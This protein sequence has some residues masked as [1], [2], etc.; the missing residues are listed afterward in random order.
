[1][2]SERG[3]IFAKQSFEDWF[4]TESDKI[5]SSELVGFVMGIDSSGI[6]FSKD[7]VDR[8][9]KKMIKNAEKINGN[10]IFRTEYERKNSPEGRCGITLAHGDAYK[11]IFK[12]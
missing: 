2:S 1:M 5:E 3:V 6:V 7:S 11:I 10:Y 8:A 4:K 12:E 9:T